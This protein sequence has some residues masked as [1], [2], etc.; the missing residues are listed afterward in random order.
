MINSVND[1]KK[2]HQRE[3]LFFNDINLI[4]GIVIIIST[5][6][7]IIVHTF[8]RMDCHLYS[9]CFNLK[10]QLILQLK[11]YTLIMYTFSKQGHI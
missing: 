9:Y 5:S 7:E 10:I 6:Y 8:V 4:V 1:R 3:R 11:F 2:S